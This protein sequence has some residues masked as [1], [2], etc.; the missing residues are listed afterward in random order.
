MDGTDS[1]LNAADESLRSREALHGAKGRHSQAAT[2]TQARRIC[3]DLSQAPGAHRMLPEALNCWDRLI[4]AGD[5]V[6]QLAVPI[7]APPR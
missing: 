5:R 4:C 7:Y 2:N 1:L 6:W 3:S